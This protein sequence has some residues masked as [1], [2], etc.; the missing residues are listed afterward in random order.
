MERPDPSSPKFLS[1]NLVG[2]RNAPRLRLALPATLLT[3]F[4][5]QHCILIDISQTGA[6]VSLGEPLVEESAV[7]LYIGG[8]ELFGFVVRRQIGPKGGINGLEFEAPLA[9]ADVLAIRAYSET[10]EDET[11]RE[12][13]GMVREWVTGC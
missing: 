10:Y 1:G 13:R 11:R 3:I 5:R 6:Q 2:R 9:E 4:G 8:F 7:E 12:F